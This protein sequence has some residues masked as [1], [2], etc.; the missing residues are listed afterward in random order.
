MILGFLLAMGGG[1][2]A[3]ADDCPRPPKTATIC[4]GDKVCKGTG[5]V[6]GDDGELTEGDVY[7]FYTPPRRTGGKK[8]AN[9]PCPAGYNAETI[10]TVDEACTAAEGIALSLCN[11]MEC[12]RAD[13]SCTGTHC[14]AGAPQRSGNCCTVVA[15]PHC[16]KKKTL[17]QQQCPEC[18]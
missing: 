11:P 2:A 3:S 12:K 16:V 1:L 17:K 14:D 5:P 15:K 18:E 4:V 13:P 6:I 7:T 9:P 10:N 8:A